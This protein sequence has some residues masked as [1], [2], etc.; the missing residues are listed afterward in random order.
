M[1]KVLSVTLALLLAFSC[2]FITASAAGDSFS[3]A[4]TISFNKTYSD[5]VTTT[6]AND[7]YKFTISTSGTVTVNFEA[8]YAY[9]KLY[10][11]D[12]N[13]TEV[14]NNTYITA[15]S[16]GEISYSKKLMLTSG[17]YYLN[18]SRYSSSYTGAY[19]L[20]LSF[21][22]S[23][24]SFTET[25]SGS[26][27]S[28]NTANSISLNTQYKG[29]VGINDESDYYKFTLSSANSVTVDFKAE[30]S[31]AKLYIYNSSKSEVWKNTYV[32]A[33]SSGEI[34]YS[35]KVDLS[36]GTYYFRVCRYGSEYNSSIEYFGNYSFKITS[37]SSSSS[38]TSLNLSVSNSSVSIKE[39]ASY[40]VTC[41]YSGTYSGSLTISYSIANTDIAKC[42]WGSWNS[43]KPPLTITGLKEGSTTITVK[44]KDSSTGTVFDTET[45]KVTV[46]APD[47]GSSGSSGGSSGSSSSSSSNGSGVVSVIVNIIT[48]PL[49][50]ILWLLELLF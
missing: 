35:Q 38:S 40:K 42:E 3:N 7:Y 36:A 27:N 20:Y 41:S 4:T 24:E 46:T 17:T 12:S 50:L 28:F 18:V 47:S 19:K 13:R 21:S 9:A 25:G 26:N 33:N 10:L 29:M 2:L 16:S 5:S 6:A 11:Y 43:G 44:L 23:S 8:E 22:S 32:T 48:F 37:S 15:N 14:W 34:S 30:L 1:K 45:I 39:G 49:Q 31:Y